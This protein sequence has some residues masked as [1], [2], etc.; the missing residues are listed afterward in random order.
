MNK[1]S[2]ELLLANNDWNLFFDEINR[3][4]IVEK[5]NDELYLLRGKAYY[6]LGNWQK[7]IEDFMKAQDINSQSP[8]KH[9]L[10]LAQNILAYRN[11]DIYGG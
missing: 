8:A 7:A 3:L 4:L 9:M 2:L 5:Q 11:E 10:Q 1:E 6:K